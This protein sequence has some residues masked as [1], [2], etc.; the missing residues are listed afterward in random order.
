MLKTAK[1][2]A[3][4]DDIKLVSVD[5]TI[6]PYRQFS[7]AVYYNVFHTGK[8]PLLRQQ[9]SRVVED[10]GK[11]T[12][13]DRKDISDST[14]LAAET[15]ITL[16]DGTSPTIKELYD[17]NEKNFWVLSCDTENQKIVPNIAKEVIQT[18]ISTELV[19]VLLDNNQ[20]IRCTPDHLF[21]LRNGTYCPAEELRTDTSLMPLYI[22]SRK[23][24]KDF[25]N[26]YK[27]PFTGKGEALYRMV[28]R[29]TKQK[30]V[31]ESWI[32]AAKD[33][34]GFAVI[35]HNNHVK[36]DDRPENLIPLTNKE[37]RKLHGDIFVLYNKSEEKRNLTS[38]LCKQRKVG[39][40][41]VHD[42]NPEK[43]KE[44]SASNGRISITQYNKSDK[45][46]K[47]AAVRGKESIKHAL[48][49]IDSQARIDM[50]DT[51]LS[52]RKSDPE[53]RA[54]YDK[55]TGNTIRIYNQYK[56]YLA[57]NK[58]SK[59]EFPYKKWKEKI[60]Q[61]N[62]KVVSVTRITV[63]EPVYDLVMETIHNF[64]IDS[65]VFVHNCGAIHN[66]IM[67]TKDVPI[68]PRTIKHPTSEEMMRSIFKEGKV[69]RL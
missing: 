34:S 26:Y 45:H 59:L 31:S 29:E 55:A 58:F 20:V 54:R 23:T 47:D 8:C 22:E 41:F 43:F 6:D 9:M 46:R 32:R 40:G 53:Y 3:D 1:V 13:D 39:F 4:P 48:K 42:S 51:R 66:A 16:L 60:F 61:H 5:R 49:Y 67:N 17:R 12:S 19:E 37:H 62:H 63:A 7:N 14:C 38:E 35:H 18:K 11:P 65:G 52:K 44:T 30:E 69:V 15:K 64:R 10:E 50:I 68:Y 24:Y 28:S 21:L 33:N 2:T 56:K 36:I 25:Y 57:D 27:D